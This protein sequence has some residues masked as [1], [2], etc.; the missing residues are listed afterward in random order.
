MRREVIDGPPGLPLV[1]GGVEPIRRGGFAWNAGNS[2]RQ[3]LVVYRERDE[4]GILDDKLNLRDTPR[5]DRG[6]TCENYRQNERKSC[7]F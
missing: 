1:R 6:Y 5:R 4:V 3:A 7:D 2:E